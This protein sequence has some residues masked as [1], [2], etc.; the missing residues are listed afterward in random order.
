MIDVWELD[1]EGKVW[2]Q[3]AASYKLQASR[4]VTVAGYMPFS[5]PAD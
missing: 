2:L 1:A 4:R 3:E 5:S